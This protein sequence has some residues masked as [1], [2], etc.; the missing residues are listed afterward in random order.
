MDN[1]D[2][3]D[4]RMRKNQRHKQTLKSRQYYLEY[5]CCCCGGGG[6]SP[7]AYE[8]RSSRITIDTPTWSCTYTG[9]DTIDEKLKITLCLFFS[10][11]L[12][13]FSTT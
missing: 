6:G 5:D 1:N 7:F 3:V 8:R 2:D 10:L 11:S 4:H 12:S 9:Q 13:S